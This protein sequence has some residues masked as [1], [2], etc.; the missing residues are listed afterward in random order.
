M[1]MY[2]C[3]NHVKSLDL[4]IHKS[5]VEPTDS[6]P[7]KSS[8]PRKLFRW[9]WETRDACWLWCWWMLN[10]KMIIIVV[11]VIV[12]ICY[13]LLSLVIISNHSL[14]S[15]IIIVDDDDDGYIIV[16]IIM[17]IIRD[18][19]HWLLHKSH[20]YDAVSTILICMII[21]CSTCLKKKKN[22]I[23]YHHYMKA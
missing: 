11:V 13:H 2:V 18:D 19:G 10:L 22:I 16:M 20:C 14:T 21:T 15:L 6:R 4:L 12:V 7:R 8:L 5:T 17:I 23:T 1:Y 9:S 3:L